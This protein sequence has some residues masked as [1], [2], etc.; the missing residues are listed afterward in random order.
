[1]RGYG[2]VVV[3]DN[4]HTV[5]TRPL[6]LKPAVDVFKPFR[7]AAETEFEKRIREIMMENARELSMGRMRNVRK[8]DGPSCTSVPHHCASNSVAE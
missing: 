7:V 8:R 3:D 2:Y 1:M 4:S 5:Y 6:R